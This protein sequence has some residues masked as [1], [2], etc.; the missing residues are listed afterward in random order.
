MPRMV[1]ICTPVS[2]NFF[3]QPVDQD[4]DGFQVDVRV[5][6]K[7]AVQDLLLV[8]RFAAFLDQHSQNRMFTWG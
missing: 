4:L 6:R 3:A 7:D 8:H 2:A 1:T 5:V